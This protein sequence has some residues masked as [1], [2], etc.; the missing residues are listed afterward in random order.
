MAVLKDSSGN[1]TGADIQSV[2]YGR[3]LGQGCPG[4][5]LVSSCLAGTRRTPSF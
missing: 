5:G 1:M 3:S 4:P 2:E